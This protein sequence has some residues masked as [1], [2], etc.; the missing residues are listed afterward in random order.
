MAV[1]LPILGAMSDV[2]QQRK[3]YVVFFTIICIASTW[4]FIIANDL[5][6]VLI[7]FSISMIT[8]Q[9]AQVFYDSMLPGIVPPGKE[10]KLSSIAITIGYFGGAMMMETC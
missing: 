7:L 3:N 9:W 6:L 10:A 1:M 4:L 8:Y 5:L 2:T